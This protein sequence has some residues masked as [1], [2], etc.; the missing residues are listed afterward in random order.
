LPQQVL[1]DVNYRHLVPT[2]ASIQ[3]QQQLRALSGN[4]GLWFA[5]GYLHPYDS[6]ETALVSAMD[7]AAAI[8]PAAARLRR[9]V[10]RV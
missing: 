6:Q 2:P 3:A 1:H 7:V 9:F 4:G 5:G 10:R 8:A